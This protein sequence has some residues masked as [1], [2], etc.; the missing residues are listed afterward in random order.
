M[1]CLNL[2]NIKTHSFKTIYKTYYS[3]IF[4]KGVGETYK[5][6]YVII[7][8]V[9]LT[10]NNKTIKLFKCYKFR[11]GNLIVRLGNRIRN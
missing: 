1:K 5:V 9:D 6:N 3:D 11:L 2:Y 7:S 4:D 10:K 8:I